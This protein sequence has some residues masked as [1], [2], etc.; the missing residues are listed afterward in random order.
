[1]SHFSQGDPSSSPSLLAP[2]KMTEWMPLHH[3]KP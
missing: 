1:V 3:A 2:A